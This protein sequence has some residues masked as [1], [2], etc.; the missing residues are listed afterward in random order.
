MLVGYV[1]CT[2]ALHHVLVEDGLRK[3]ASVLDALDEDSDSGRGN[4]SMIPS[5][6]IVRHLALYTTFHRSRANRIVHA[7]AVPLIL[8]T[9]LCWLAQLGSPVSPLLNVGTLIALT[10]CAVL[11]TVDAFG[12]ACLLGPLMVACAG[13]G[14]MVRH[15]SPVTILP[16]SAIVHLLAWYVTVVIAHGELEPQLDV[17][18]Q[19]RED[20]NLYFRRR[21]F[22]AHHL[23]TRVGPLDALVQFSIAPLAV[24]QDALVLV[25]LRHSLERAIAGERARVP[26]RIAARTSP[27]TSE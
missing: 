14:L 22:L 25:G 17:G 9:G 20:S 23:G 4:A 21:Y 5:L 16:A 6:G 27:L 8:F 19:H 18:T 26:D 11:A 2:Q 1:L 12:A 15:V 10:M 13:A 7:V 3:R 24:V